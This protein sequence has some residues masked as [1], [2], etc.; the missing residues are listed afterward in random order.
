MEPVENDFDRHALHIGAD[1]E[2]GGLMYAGFTAAIAA[3]ICSALSVPS[4]ARM[5]VFG[6]VSAMG[7]AVVLIAIV[8]HQN[9]GRA[10]LRGAR[11]MVSSI[12]EP[13][14]PRFTTRHPWL[15][16]RG[17][18]VLRWSLVLFPAVAPVAPLDVIVGVWLGMVLLTMVLVAPLATKSGWRFHW[19]LALMLAVVQ[20]QTS[21][22]TYLDQFGERS[23]TREVVVIL[24]LLFV[25]TASSHI[26]KYALGK[27]IPS[28][29]FQRR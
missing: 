27:P 3:G 29:A 7:V 16:A 2:F 13:D 14:V 11:R 19:V 5:P 23:P 9:G 12:R 10:F 15:I 26:A 1:V 21:A 28:S 8:A 22:A 20:V 24:L 25:G 6:G 4:F 18:T 17:Q